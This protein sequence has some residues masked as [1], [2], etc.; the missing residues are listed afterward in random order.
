MLDEGYSLIL[1]R[2]FGIFTSFALARRCRHHRLHSRFEI[3]QIQSK[4]QQAAHG[5]RV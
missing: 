2:F 1:L 3:K 5:K 4:L